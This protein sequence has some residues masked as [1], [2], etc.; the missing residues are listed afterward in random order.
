MRTTLHW[1]G[2]C[3]SLLFTWAKGSGM[4]HR[5][6]FLYLG[7]MWESHAG[8][9]SGL[10]TRGLSLPEAL[11]SLIWINPAHTAACLLYI[12]R[13]MTVCDIYLC[14]VCVYECL[15]VHVRRPE[16]ALGVL[17]YYSLLIPCRQSLFSSNLGLPIFLLGWVASKPQWSSFVSP[18]PHLSV[19]EIQ[20]CVAVCS[21]Y[22]GV[23]EPHECT[24]IILDLEVMDLLL[25]ILKLPMW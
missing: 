19:L 9:L 24:R 13:G 2:P 4:M 1:R 17:L 25:K 12:S 23:E 22:G 15:C 7:Y 11:S 10:I 5:T 20:A 18:P 21:F 14:R 16:K 6:V 3:E 8:L